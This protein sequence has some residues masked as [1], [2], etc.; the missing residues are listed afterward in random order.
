MNIHVWPP[1]GGITLHH[2]KSTTN[3]PVLVVGTRVVFTLFWHSSSTG[4]VAD[5]INHLVG[6]LGKSSQLTK[7]II[8]QRGRKQHQPDKSRE[9][10]LHPTWPCRNSCRRLCG[11]PSLKSTW[12]SY[13]WIITWLW[14]LWSG[15]PHF[16]TFLIYNTYNMYI[17]YKCWIFHSY[18]SF[19]LHWMPPTWTLLEGSHVVEPF[20]WRKRTH[21]PKVG[22]WSWGPGDALRY[23]TC[24]ILMCLKYGCIWEWCFHPPGSLIEIRKSYD[25][26]NKP[27]NLMVFALFSDKPIV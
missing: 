27:W 23:Q 20:W 24:S 6:G 12:D 15:K 17:I 5:S 22:V 3:Q 7:S 4:L 19:T 2:W 8:F 26:I 21:I 25:N 10:A 18:D 14:K 1:D 16:Y 13:R 9:V 11:P